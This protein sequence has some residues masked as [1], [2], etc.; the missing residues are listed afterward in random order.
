MLLLFIP[1]ATRLTRLLL[2]LMDRSGAIRL[3]RSTITLG[4]IAARPRV[5]PRR[6]LLLLLTNDGQLLVIIFPTRYAQKIVTILIVSYHHR[7]LGRRG[8]TRRNCLPTFFHFDL[9][10]IIFV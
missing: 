3:A 5:M 6:T 2:N 4:L 8:R 7:S 9:G 10:L 1:I